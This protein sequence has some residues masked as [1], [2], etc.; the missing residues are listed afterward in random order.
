[1]EQGTQEWVSARLGKLT[2]SRIADALAKTKS[3][4][5]ASRAN[6]ITTLV[7]ERLKGEASESYTN[8]AMQWGTD[9]EPQAR[10]AYEFYR[11]IDV[12]E[13]GFIEHPTIAM[14]GCSPDGLVGDDGL[15]EIKCPSSATH[16]DTLRGDAIDG[17]YIKQM[18]WQMVCTGRKWCDFVSFDPRF[19]AEMQLHVTR[20]NRDNVMISELEREAKIFLSEVEQ[21]L[22][23][24]VALYRPK[25][26][27][28]E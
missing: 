18:M 24:L 15:V 21:T 4:W 23:E 10:S 12:Q 13:V 8:A 11:D 17:K 25:R 1:M 6:L 2:A 22:G 26:K 3:G 5:G 7:L 19:P 28:A 20:V 27:A 9:T 14:S 16:L